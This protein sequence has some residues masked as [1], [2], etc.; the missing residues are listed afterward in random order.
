[1][2][3]NEKFLEPLGN[4]LDRI[5]DVEK[6]ESAN[7]NLSLIIAGKEEYGYA[8]NFELMSKYVAE[9]MVDTIK[10]LNN[11]S[12]KEKIVLGL[13]ADTSPIGVYEEFSK[14]AKQENL[15]L[16]KIFVVRYE[17]SYG[18]LIKEDSSFN[19][20][21]FHKEK[22]FQLNGVEIFPAEVEKDEHGK[23]TTKGNFLPMFKQYD[24]KKEGK[25]K[26]DI[27]QV[28]DNYENILNKLGGIDFALTGVGKDG[29]ILNWGPNEKILKIRE[30][31]EKT[32]EE[33]N[34]NYIRFIGKQDHRN[35]QWKDM[36]STSAKLFGISDEEA[37]RGVITT[38]TLGIRHIVG[39]KKLIIIAPQATKT[40]TVKEI[41]YGE[42]KRKDN[43]MINPASSVVKMR[44]VLGKETLLVLT[45]EAA[46]EINKNGKR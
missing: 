36:L 30:T 12:E 1:M 3:I 14:I 2:N 40:E 15:D 4:K 37:K 43:E 16:S 7:N 38:A 10:E 41:F 19:F 26:E 21:N 27:K 9:L 35:S 24:E 25:A 20:D 33:Y 46:K 44:N 28:I 5:K 42:N 23:E 34:K 31:R 32:P 45:P 13:A 6:I 17:Q 29:H 18:P 39:A 22:F 11:D 8:K